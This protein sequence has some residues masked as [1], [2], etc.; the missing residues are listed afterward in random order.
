MKNFDLVT[1]DVGTLEDFIYAVVDDALE[2]KGCSMD[3]QL[4][5]AVSDT[6]VS[7]W[8]RWLQEENA[9]ESLRF[10]DGTSIWGRQ[11]NG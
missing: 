7:D 10:P 5:E 9:D 1:Q 6:K 4:P 8:G 2:A 11:N 3:L